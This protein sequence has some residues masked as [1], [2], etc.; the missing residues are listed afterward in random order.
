[1]AESRLSSVSKADSLEKMGEFWD[2]HDFTDLDP[3]G[4]D[5]ELK[6]RCAVP[7]KSKLFARLEKQARRHGVNVETLFNPWLQQKV[8]EAV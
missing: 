8:S 3:G 5:A 1:M 7:V 4:P 2:Q 6:V